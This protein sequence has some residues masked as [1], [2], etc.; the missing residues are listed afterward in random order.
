MRR[1]QL[2]VMVS[3]EVEDNAD[4]NTIEVGSVALVRHDITQVEL[5]N[6]GVMLRNT[7][8]RYIHG[9]VESHELKDI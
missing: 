9:R 4:P 3:V 6:G 7:N 1:I 2:A 8:F 5:G